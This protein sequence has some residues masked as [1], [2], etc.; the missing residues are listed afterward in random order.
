LSRKDRMLFGSADDP[1]V[2]R[3]SCPAQAGGK[4]SQLCL[5]LALATY[6]L[7]VWRLAFG[8]SWP[9]PLYLSMRDV[10]SSTS[11]MRIKVHSITL[12]HARVLAPQPPNL[13]P[14]RSLQTH[15]RPLPA[16]VAC[17]LS[18][19]LLPRRIPSSC[20]AVHKPLHTRPRVASARALV[21]VPIPTHQSTLP[22]HAPV[23]SH[24]L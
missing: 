13:L 15:V 16:L 3:L 5:P 12:F 14:A 11:A 19:A 9:Y 2:V 21:H 7:G 6:R 17:R 20:R 10:W 24:P 23:L 22:S 18:L 8:P 4:T 1:T